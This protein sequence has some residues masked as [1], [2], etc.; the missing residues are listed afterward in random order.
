MGACVCVEQ[1]NGRG[2]ILLV[3]SSSS[4]E[5]EPRQ[6]GFISSVDF[7]FV[8]LL[9]NYSSTTIITTMMGGM[10]CSVAAAG[11]GDDVTSFPR[12][13]ASLLFSHLSALAKRNNILVQIHP[14]P[15]CWC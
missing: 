7:F 13:V 11:K 4:V 6:G 12:I 10:R 1:R 15:R 2:G 3:L 5:E 9:V 14:A 8:L